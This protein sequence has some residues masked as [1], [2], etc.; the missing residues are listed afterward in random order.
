[1]MEDF[2]ANLTS[3]FEIVDDDIS[4][5]VSLQKFDTSDLE[6]V[7][8][9]SLPSAQFFLKYGLIKSLEIKQSQFNG[10]LTLLNN[11][12]TRNNATPSTNQNG[13]QESSSTAEN[14]SST[15][16]LDGNYAPTS[17]TANGEITE[18]KSYISYA[19]IFKPFGQNWYFDKM[20]SPQYWSIL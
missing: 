14:Q 1:M 3:I 7:F 19:N 18:R 13:S 8:D 6:H 2:D 20:L 15:T 4:Q 9:Y 12:S 17:L 10:K 16:N 11:Y 5:N